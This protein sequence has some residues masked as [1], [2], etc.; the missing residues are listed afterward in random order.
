M[1]EVGAPIS[2]DGV[3]VHLDCSCICPRY[4]QFAPENPE[5]GES[6]ESHKMVVCVSVSVCVSDKEGVVDQQCLGEGKL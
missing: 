1:A 4:L 3:A 2:L 5:D 6:P